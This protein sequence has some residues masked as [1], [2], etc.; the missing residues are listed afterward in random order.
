[1]LRSINLFRCAAAFPLAL[2]V[3][4]CSAQTE[5]APAPQPP[6]TLVTPALQ[7]V[8]RAGS[9]VDLNKWKGSTAMR[10][11]VDAN[12]ASMQKDL[13]NTLPA[14][15][16][17]A[18]A[19]PTSAAASLPVLLNMDALYNVLLRVTI[20]SRSGA[21]RDQNTALEQAAVLLD[22]A[23]RDLG[24][25]IVTAAKAQD[26]RIA[27]LQATVQQQAAALAAAAAPPPPPAAPAAAPKPKRKK[28]TTA[29]QPAP[30]Q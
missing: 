21:P 30:T 25:V 27:D 13:Q 15:L 16:T 11:E 28:A 1:M 7:S 17:A 20:A 4:Y 24:D 19:A 18:D 23:R 2:V 8:G 5:Q 3:T 22:S 12:L 29:A 6:S 9:G 10:E 14:L 26:K